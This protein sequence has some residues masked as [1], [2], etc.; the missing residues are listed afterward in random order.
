MNFKITLLLI[1]SLLAT[2][3][4]SNKHFLKTAQTTSE[5][6]IDGSSEEWMASGSILVENRIRYAVRNSSTH[7]YVLIEADSQQDIMEIT[8]AGLNI[9]WNNAGKK[10]K[11]QG[12]RFPMLSPDEQFI[13]QRVRQ[14]GSG[15]P[16]AA[17]DFAN[18]NMSFDYVALLNFDGLDEQQLL[19][20]TATELYGLVMT[21][22]ITDNN[23]FV[24]EYQIPKKIIFNSKKAEKLALL[25]ETEEIEQPRLGGGQG[26]PPGG[27]RSGGM[28][29]PP[30]GMGG[31]PPSGGGNGR[32][33]P[34]GMGHPS[35]NIGQINFWQFFHLSE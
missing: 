30:G 6:T 18:Q 33:R 24:V 9:W 31:A 7:I 5:I 25:F 34:D 22:G 14:S 16:G 26:G 28:G 35:E 1:S 10:K 2:S 12:I 21:A 13:T 23:I 15:S 3:C 32:G 20:E 11:K 4:R 27:G 19:S 29:A 17:M 8:R